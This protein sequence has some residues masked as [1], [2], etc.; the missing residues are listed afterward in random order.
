MR[1]KLDRA[2]E[3]IEKS[4][5]YSGA[6]K[7]LGVSRQ[8]LWFF[9]Q[10]HDLSI[11]KNSKAVARLTQSDIKELRKKVRSLVFTEINKKN[12]FNA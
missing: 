6:A 7:R 4:K 11:E 10:R 8:R 5:S 2:K 9:C 1:L 12:R 3:A